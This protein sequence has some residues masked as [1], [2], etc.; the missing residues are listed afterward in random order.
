M[1]LRRIGRERK[2][3]SCGNRNDWKAS[4][5]Q[6]QPPAPNGFN[7]ARGGERNAIVVPAKARKR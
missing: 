2:Q 5:A 4:I 1:G 7:S 3:N 6:L